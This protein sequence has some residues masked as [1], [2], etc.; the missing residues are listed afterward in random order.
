MGPYGPFLGR[1]LNA[2]YTYVQGRGRVPGLKRGPNHPKTT[3][4]WISMS[5]IRVK[6]DFWDPKIYGHNGRFWGHFGPTWAIFGAQFKRGLHICPRTGRGPRAKTGPQPPKNNVSG[7]FYVRYSRKN[8]FFEPREYGPKWLIL[9]FW[10]P[11]RPYWA[12]AYWEPAENGSQSIDGKT[13]KQVH[14]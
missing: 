7:D 5:G 13:G 10:G 8:R 14:R 1:N 2:D 4:Q 6:I 11:N 9:V 3:F 12:S